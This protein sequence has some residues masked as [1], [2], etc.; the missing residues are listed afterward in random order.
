MQSTRG[1]SMAVTT[2]FV[3]CFSE[4]RKAVWTLAITQSSSARSSSG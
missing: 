4:L 3:I 2:R 1:F